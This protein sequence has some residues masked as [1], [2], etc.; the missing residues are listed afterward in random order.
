MACEVKIFGNIT[1]FHKVQEYFGL[2]HDDNWLNAVN[3]SI[4][5]LGEL[6]A[7]AQGE[8]IALL[9][10]C[11]NDKS[12]TVTYTLVWC[13]EL[14]DPNE[15]IT[16]VL[17]LPMLG[18]NVSSGAEWTCIVF[19]LSSGKIVFY[20]DGGMKIF[21]QCFHEGPVLNVK[22][23]SPP[24]GSEAEPFIYFTYESCLCFMKGLDFIPHLNN[25]RYN[26]N[27]TMRH[28]NFS[29]SN[30]EATVKI[31]DLLTY[32]KLHFPLEHRTMINDS[33]ISAFYAPKIFDHCI[34]QCLNSGY[35]T[36][37][38]ENPAQS[39]IVLGVGNAPYLGFYSAEEGYKVISLGEVAKDVIGVAYRNIF[40]NIFGRSPPTDFE[41]ENQS[42]TT[43]AKDI[44]MR[45]KFQFFDDKRDAYSIAIAPNGRLAAVVDN[46]ERVMLVDC[47]KSIILRVWKGYREAQCGF[48]L[49]KE[50]T[51]KNI[52]TS[53][54]KA[55]FLVIYAPRLGCLEI[56]PL[57]RGPKVAAFTVSKNGQLIYNTHGL[58]GLSKDVK[59]IRAHNYSCLFL[60]PNDGCVKEIQIPFHYALSATNSATSRDIHLLR[61]LKN[62]LRSTESFSL[63]AEELECF[64]AEF[65]TVEVRQQCLETLLKSKQLRA[66]TFQIFTNAFTTTLA[67]QINNPKDITDL[68]SFQ[69]FYITVQN[70]QRLCDF[71]LSIKRC[72]K[73]EQLELLQ[74]S[75]NYLVIIQQLLLLLSDVLVS[76]K[77]SLLSEMQTAGRSVTFD[78]ECDELGDFFDFTSIFQVNCKNYVPLRQEKS[79]YYGEVSGKLF[80][81]FFDQGFS[82]ENFK[83]AA[84]KSTIPSQDLLILVLQYWLEKPFLYKNT[85]QII[86]DMSR[87]GAT[88]RA[89]CEVAGDVVND[90]AYNAISPWWQK[91]RELLL[92]SSKSIGLLVAIV[93][94]TVAKDLRQ[95]YKEG[96]CDEGS[97]HDEEEN[98]EQISHDEAQWALLI[99]K[100]EDIAILG[101][102][103]ECRIL[104]LEPTM[105]EIAY[106]PPS[107]SLKFIVNGGK[108]IVTDLTAQW[109]ISTRIHPS[110]IV[111]FEKSLTA[112][113]NSTKA[114]E[115]SS[116]KDVEQIPPQKEESDITDVK[117]DVVLMKLA[118]LRKHF[119]FSL[120]SGV[121]L[122]LMSWHYMIYWSKNLNSLQHF[123]AALICLEQF[124][125]DDYALKHGIG[126][127]L[128]QATIKFPLQS[129][130]KLIEKV[131]RLPKNKLCQ[132]NI[133][134]NASSLPEFLELCLDFIKH[135][136][137][138]LNYEKR[139]LHFEESLIEGPLALPYLAMQ[140]HHAVN[141]Q[142]KLHFELCAVLHFIVNF[143]LKFSKPLTTLFD[144]MSNKA[145]F[146][147]INKE[148][149]FVLPAPDPALQSLRTDFLCKVITA[150]M[151]LIRE[152]FL[153]VFVLE[154][155]E[156]ME[157]IY[158]LG[159]S[160]CLD[161]LPLRRRQIA[162][163]YSHGYDGN[164][165]SLLKDIPKDE[166]MG[167]LLLEI[168]GRRLNLYTN[169]SQK[170]FLTVASVGQQ[171]LQY[172]DNLETMSEKNVVT[173]TSQ[174]QEITPCSI[175]KLVANAI[176]CLSGKDS[177][178]VHI[179]AQMFDAG[180]LLKECDN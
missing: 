171:L 21:S 135:L 145:F 60:D 43:A 16:S 137:E 52:Q 61:R 122:S 144:A 99:A 156:Y 48:I 12:P 55:L 9:S 130:T 20:T 128:W 101:A 100:L 84:G 41:A 153:E 15:I 10:S 56:W 113:E 106:E 65:Q 146:M 83:E 1:N 176:E 24:R 32:Q 39:S 11:W 85:D 179:A 139:E 127:M 22:A 18:S 123:K 45:S 157:K 159:K 125:P 54:R 121:L 154:H 110:E 126:C 47:Q 160:W 40:G 118:L 49:V 116:N 67:Q 172:L 149:S 170:R 131:G 27:R 115:K 175:I 162:D 105:P 136:K 58:I 107:C 64:A 50:K 163:L 26:L 158:T 66:S 73:S 138:S 69:D 63:S 38:T 51:L 165:E 14:D 57:Q 132:Q 19:G 174:E 169:F 70:Y 102:I 177:P 3:C 82:V 7:L 96:S 178:Y 62:M 150:S 80:S 168:A 114:C 28:N 77:L 34:D 164:A 53:R 17:C 46:L 173:T 95:D 93:C 147:D 111:E 90:Y 25:L 29:S 129:A 75:D 133:D 68:E 4:S 44:Q 134:M 142:L 151:D 124:K 112:D 98:W 161:H 109:L 89:I 104:C 81:A 92:Q 31:S 87:L 94:K 91:V 2:G 180:N 6:V 72:V 141:N 120:Q 155:T 103:I 148:L 119:P 5:P 42:S 140:Q 33:A 59:K 79:C 23:Y 71:Y 108:G 13:G 117:R 76:N 88:I 78:L 37:I 143:Q 35:Y 166:H 167:R 152:D 74:F 86:E 8:K 30:A 97:Q 36:R